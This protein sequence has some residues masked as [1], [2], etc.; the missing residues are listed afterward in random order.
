MGQSKLEFRYAGSGGYV[1]VYGQH[2]PRHGGAGRRYHTSVELGG[3]RLN[4]R[5]TPSRGGD[6]VRLYGLDWHG[7]R[8]EWQR[9]EH[10]LYDQSLILEMLK[11]PTLLD[12]S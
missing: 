8:D 5:F 7:Q 1:F 6:S 9:I 3:Q 2:T 12:R 4:Y 11:Q 10:E